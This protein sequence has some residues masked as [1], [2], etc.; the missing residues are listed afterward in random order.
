LRTLPFYQVGVFTHRPFGG[1]P[2][3]VFPDAEGLTAAGPPAASMAREGLLPPD[4]ERVVLQ[5][6]QIGRLSFLT[7]AGPKGPAA[8]G[9]IQSATSSPRR[10][11][12]PGPRL[13]R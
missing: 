11:A 7:G 8:Q 3:A 13:S 1:N 12:G 2:L 9:L 5:S 4:D 6:R 10:R